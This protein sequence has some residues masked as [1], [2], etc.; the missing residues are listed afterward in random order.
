MSEDTSDG[1]ADQPFVS[2]EERVTAALAAELWEC[3]VCNRTN[4]RAGVT[5]GCRTCTRRWLGE[6]RGGR[7]SR[8]TAR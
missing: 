3:P 8:R 5:W 7:T 4:P 2:R 1:F 6:G